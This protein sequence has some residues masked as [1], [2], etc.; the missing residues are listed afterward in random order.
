MAD[1]GLGR[2]FLSGVGETEVPQLGPETSPDRIM[3]EKS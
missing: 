1:P 2:G 3:G